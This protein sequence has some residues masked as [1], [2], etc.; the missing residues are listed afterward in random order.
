M[1]FQFRLPDIGEGV[2]EG[3]IVKWLVK[4]GDEVVEDQPIV[5]VMTDKATVEIPSPVRGKIA[6]RH[7]D[8]GTTIAVGAVIVEVETGQAAAPKPEPAAKSGERYGFGTSSGRSTSDTSILATP[9]VRKLAREKGIDL[10]NVK[11]SGPAGRI[12]LDDLAQYKPEPETTAR[13]PQ[14]EAVSREGLVEQIPYRGLR[15]RI[16]EHL[17]V[18]KSTA[19]HYTYVEEVDMTEMVRLRKTFIALSGAQNQK[20]TYLPFVIKA[21]I[22][23]LRKFP[24]LNS[25]LDEENELILVRRYFNIGI[26]TATESGLI[27]PVVKDADSKSILQLA[28][29]IGQLSEAARQGK[30]K[31]EDLK[32]STFTITSL[33]P[34]GGLF[35][36]PI[37][38]YPEVAIVG[39]H[40]ITP[41]PVVRDGQIVIRDMMNLSVSLD[42]RVVDGAIA[43]DFVQQ[44]ALYL[45]N[46]GLLALG[47]SD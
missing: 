1:S 31:V 19:P 22:E 18:S 2:V 33:G 7:G 17:A 15:R 23:G 39:L 41:R 35:A 26:A 8:E 20:L 9:A 38:N 21:V 34:L 16:G 3:E 37:I 32:D 12:T 5:E 46:P 6:K 29:E 44:V 24:L 40:K 14:V 13:V 11:G 10:A 43:A 42:H 27:V 4:E 30:L 45:E 36:T 28:R 25:T 47:P